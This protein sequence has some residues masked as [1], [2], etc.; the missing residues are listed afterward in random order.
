MGARMGKGKGLFSHWG[1]KLKSGT[2]LVEICGIKKSILLNA[3]KTGKT[4]LPIK[5]KICN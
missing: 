3:L 2:I 4:K 1:A 5:T